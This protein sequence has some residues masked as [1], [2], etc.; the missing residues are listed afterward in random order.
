MYIYR[1]IVFF[2]YS[3]WPSESLSLSAMRK[4]RENVYQHHF[5]KLLSLEEGE[6]F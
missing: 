4:R 6:T 2:I 1:Y 3:H 5:V